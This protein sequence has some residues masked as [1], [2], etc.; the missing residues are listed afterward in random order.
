MLFRSVMLADM[1]GY[2]TPQDLMRD[3]IH[4]S[5][6]G[7]RKMAAVWDW[8]INEAHEKG[9][10]SAPPHSNNF[11]D[12]ETTTTC[13]KEFASG[14]NDPR[15]GTMVLFAGHSNIRTDGQ[16]GP[17]QPNRR[18][19][20]RDQ[21]SHRR[22]EQHTGGG[23]DSRECHQLRRLPLALIG[24]GPRQRER[25]KLAEDACAHPSPEH[26]SS[27]TVLQPEQRRT[28]PRGRSDPNPPANGHAI[29]VLLGDVGRAMEE[30]RDTRGARVKHRR[31]DTIGFLEP[32][33]STRK[34]PDYT[35]TRA[36]LPDTSPSSSRP[37]RATTGTRWQR[38]RTR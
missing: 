26:M 21:S 31:N 14:A 17:T 35:P 4:P 37:G 29:S 9:W 36:R 10:I 5:V 22:S 3:G 7:N 6:E 28:P 32:A 1:A 18:L 15:S 34:P 24:L 38:P 2:I 25:L 20:H 11:N 30:C 12:G 8:A 16:K 19:H 33:V 23:P 13:K 27:V